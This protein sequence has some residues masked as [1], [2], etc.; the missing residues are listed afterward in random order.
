MC[1]EWQTTENPCCRNPKKRAG[2]YNT[3]SEDG[4]D[5]YDFDS[6]LKDI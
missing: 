6:V 2:I 1:I 3:F 4:R 5:F